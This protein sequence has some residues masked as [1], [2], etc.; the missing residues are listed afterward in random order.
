MD[1]A[2]LAWPVFYFARNGAN[3]SKPKND[4]SNQDESQTQEVAGQ[5]PTYYLPDLGTSVKANSAEEAVKIAEATMKKNK[6]SK[7]DE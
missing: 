1:D 6:K 7:E 5:T 4:T 3:M 2:G